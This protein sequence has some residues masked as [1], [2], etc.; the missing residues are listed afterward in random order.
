MMNVV[1]SPS[2]FY[3]HSSP[4]C[5]SEKLSADDKQEDSQETDAT[6]VFIYI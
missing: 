2:V 3:G 5:F 4:D 1:F 6:I